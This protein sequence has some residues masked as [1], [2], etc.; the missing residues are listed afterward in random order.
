MVTARLTMVVIV[1]IVTVAMAVVILAMATVVVIANTL[2]VF[3]IS[4]PRT[5]TFSNILLVN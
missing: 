5:A 3:S 2:K 1:G 4:R